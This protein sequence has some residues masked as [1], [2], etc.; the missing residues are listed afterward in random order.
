[1]RRRLRYLLILVLVFAAIFTIFDGIVYTFATSAMYKEADRQ[2]ADAQEAVLMDEDGA[3]ENFLSGKNVVYTGK[4]TYIITYKIFLI[5]RDEEGNVLNEKY[6]LNFDYMLGIGFSASDAGKFK[7]ETSE[8]NGNKQYYRTHTVKVTTSDGAVYYVQMATE[9]TDTHESL[10]TIFGVLIKCTVFAMVLVA[11]LGWFLSRTLSKGVIEAFEKQ[12]EFISYAS[13]EIRAPLS[14]IHTSM[15]LLL[16][17]PSAKIIDRSDLILNAL[18][19]TNGLRKMVSNLLEMAQLQASEM[20]LKREVFYLGDVVTDIID[21]FMIQ[22]E[23]GE[24]TLTAETQPGQVIRADRQLI[25]ELIAILLENA[26]K[27]T[28][29]GDKITISTREVGGVALITV[30]DTGVGI[31]EE[32]REKIFTRFYRE[33]RKK[34]AGKDGSGLG[35]YIASLIVERHG[36]KISADHNYPKGTVFMVTLPSGIRWS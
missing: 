33:D 2:F 25:T 1:M 30:S 35:L 26:V 13:H 12:D 28:E 31:G 23:L 16:E 5:V 24:K 19:Q 34:E 18:S 8:R 36:G 27:Y 32:A 17:T 9:V 7:S 6:L 22:A 14:V 11:V 3:M 15:E 4:G 29:S 10:R 20:I 21:H